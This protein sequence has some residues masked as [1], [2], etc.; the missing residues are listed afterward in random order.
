MG[1]LLHVHAYGRII[2]YASMIVTLLG[3][4]YLF[5]K[6]VLLQRRAFTCKEWGYDLRD[7][8]ED[9]RLNVGRRSTEPSEN[10]FSLVALRR[11]PSPSTA[12]LR[13]LSSFSCRL[14]SLATQ[15]SPATL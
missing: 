6:I 14:R 12:G 9:R 8:P 3:A 11:C 7:L 1:E 15:S 10:A 2:A 13:R 4:F 5:E